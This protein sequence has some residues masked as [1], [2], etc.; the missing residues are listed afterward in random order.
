MPLPRVKSPVKTL[1]KSP[2]QRNRLIAR[3]SSSPARGAIVRDNAVKSSSQPA[4]DQ[5]ATKRRLDFRS[6]ESGGPHSLSQPTRSL[7]NGHRLQPLQQD[8]DEGSEQSAEDDG[9][10]DFVE[11]SMAMLSGGDD[12]DISAQS[13]PQVA[14]SE[15]GE[16][17]GETSADQEEG[18]HAALAQKKRG[19]PP[20]QKETPPARPSKPPKKLVRSVVEEDDVEDP[21]EEDEPPADEDEEAVVPKKRGGTHKAGK[22]KGTAREQPPPRGPKK[23]RSLN[24]EESAV[25]AE[26]SPEPQPKRQRTEPTSQSKKPAARQPAASS[27]KKDAEPT[28]TGKGPRGRKR[29]SSIDPGDVS[30]VMVARRP[31]LPKSRG[32]LINRREVPGDSGAMIRTRSG[33]NS[34]KPL[35]YWRNERVDY[36]KDEA[37]DAYSGRTHRSRFVLPSIKEVV[38]V[39]EPE[40]EFRPKSRKGKKGGGRGKRR[41]RGYASDD[42]DDDDGLADLWEL[43]PGT[44]TGEVVVWQPEYEFS[45]PAPNDLVSVMD[46]QLAISGAAIKTTE[47]VGGEFR[48]AKVFSEGFIGAGVVDL[49]PGAMK[50]LK[51]SRKVFMIF[52]VHY[53]RVLV[54]VQETSFRISKGGIFI[55]PRC[56]SMPYPLLFSGVILY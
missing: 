16:S 40:P 15:G 41:S 13:E 55:V 28:Q 45:P 44:V 30:Q 29:K 25:P 17:E 22:A 50:R 9:V 32:L 11:E 52:F 4:R 46:K 24:E 54:T 38:R 39:D 43:D 5:A 56:E 27:K 12:Y 48:Y 33:R 37:E 20:K 49:P 14:A 47:V 51:N 36:E 19:R 53:G 1:L 35:A 3:N 34:F 18:A 8:S 42:D 23:R 10:D 7:T 6:V 2:A 21:E 26:P 31:P